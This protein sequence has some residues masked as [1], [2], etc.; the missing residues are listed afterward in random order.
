MRQAVAKDAVP[1]RVSALRSS[2]RTGGRFDTRL[3]SR[4]RSLSHALT[5]SPDHWARSK[6]SALATRQSPFCQTSDNVDWAAGRF[7]RPP[8]R[9]QLNKHFAAKMHMRNPPTHSLPQ[10]NPPCTR[11]L[12]LTTRIAAL[13]ST[14]LQPSSMRDAATPRL[15]GPGSWALGVGRRRPSRCLHHCLRAAPRAPLLPLS[16]TLVTVSCHL[17]LL[18]RVG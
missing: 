14:K 15:L 13:P 8:P 4:L 1:C 18:P 2:S 3:I 16:L 10:L 11:S 6:Y 12:Y 17:P 5:P 9:L 7:L